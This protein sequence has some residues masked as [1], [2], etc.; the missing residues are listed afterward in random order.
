L[1]KAFAIAKKA[2]LE[3]VYLGNVPGYKEHTYCPKCGE[4]LVERFGLSAVSVKLKTN[5]CPK[6]GKR[7]NIVL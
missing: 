3:Y 1:D 2:G 4:L 7:I 6:C 5:K